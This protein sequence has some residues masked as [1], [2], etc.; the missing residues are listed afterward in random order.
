M[1]ALFM[2]VLLLFLTLCCGSGVVTVEFS[3]EKDRE[4]ALRRNKNYIGK[5]DC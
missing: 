4:M 2:I 1:N 3:S 5:S